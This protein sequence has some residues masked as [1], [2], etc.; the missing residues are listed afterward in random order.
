MEARSCFYGGNGPARREAALLK[1]FLDAD[2]STGVPSRPTVRRDHIVRYPFSFSF[3]HH[4]RGKNAKVSDSTGRWR[5]NRYWPVLMKSRSIPNDGRWQQLDT[6]ADICCARVPCKMSAFAAGY[7][8]N[9]DA[10]RR[11]CILLGVTLR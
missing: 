7:A 6:Q 5:T 3:G 8:S 4:G 11:T 10:T 1:G 9:R 2:L